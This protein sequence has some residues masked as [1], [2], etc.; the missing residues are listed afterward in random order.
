MDLLLFLL[1]FFLKPDQC[2][3]QKPVIVGLLRIVTLYRVYF[4]LRSKLTIKHLVL[5]L[6]PPFYVF[7]FNALEALFCC[8]IQPFCNFSFS[9]RADVSLLKLFVQLEG[10]KTRALNIMIQ[11]IPYEYQAWTTLYNVIF[12]SYS[13]KTE[14]WLAEN[15]CSAR[16]TKDGPP[17]S[18]VSIRLSAK[19]W[20]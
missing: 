2:I 11:S 3:C 14:F 7:V 12:S 6:P 10:P 4:Y 20:F 17:N 16:S 15:P 5:F 1:P 19:N 13:R 18:D 8:R 9:R